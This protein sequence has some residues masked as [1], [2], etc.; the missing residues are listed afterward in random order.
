MSLLSKIHC[1]SSDVDQRLAELGLDRQTFDTAAEENY[2]A[3]AACTP[4]HPATYPGFSAW[5]EANRSLADNLIISRWGEKQSERNLPL[6]V[7]YAQTIAITAS[8]GD[9]DTGREDGFPCTSSSKGQCT[10]DFLRVNKKQQ[11]FA[12]M[13]DPAQLAAM[14][15]SGRTTWIFL[16]H[17][18][19]QLGEIRY[20][21]SRPISM[22]EDGHVDNWAERIIF[23]PRPFDT[24]LQ[25]L[26]NG[27][28]TGG[29]S[30]EIT[31][32]IQKRG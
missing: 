3:F 5:A 18:D 21:L 13:E 24:G 25:M 15:T 10:A 4:N 14:K 23:P 26:G 9:A 19:M 17:R 12:F 27:N 6:V 29:Q 28:G 8:S 1:D 7:N 11:K 20:E 31:V 22:S 32:E 2:A 16:I 30:P